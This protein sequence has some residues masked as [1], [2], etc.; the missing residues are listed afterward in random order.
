MITVQGKA[1]IIT[2]QKTF[3]FFHLTLLQE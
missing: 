1:Y 2:K 3:I